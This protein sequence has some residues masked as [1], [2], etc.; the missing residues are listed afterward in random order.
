MKRTVL[1]L[2]SLFILLTPVVKAQDEAMM[3][4]WQEFMTPGEMHKLM[5]S[6]N[7]TW[8]V[9]ISSW[10]DPKSPPEKS[11]ATAEN[12]TIF[13][14]LYQVGSFTGTMMGMPFEGKSLLAY[15]NAKKMFVSTWVDNMG[16]GVVIMTGKWN[17]K[18]KTLEL[19]GTM[20]DPMTGKDAAMRETVQVIDANT[21]KMILYMPGMDGKEMKSMEMAMKRKI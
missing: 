17:E 5:G 12:K 9:D 2:A 18:T 10:M 21:Q 16:S 3:K 13:N 8:T 19:S 14:G 6:W 4:A 7:G 1:F 15:D 11:T 20:T